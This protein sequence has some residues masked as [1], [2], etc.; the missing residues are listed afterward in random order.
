MLQK[1]LLSLGLEYLDLYLMHWPMGFKV[2]KIVHSVCEWIPLTFST[3]A[4]TPTKKMQEKF[5]RKKFMH[6]CTFIKPGLV[7]V[8]ESAPQL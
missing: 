2:R 7:F 3:P 6:M 4:P 1:S 8:L 5:E